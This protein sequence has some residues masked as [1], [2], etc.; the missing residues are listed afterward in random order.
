MFFLG[1]EF[2]KR[3][4]FCGDQLTVERARGS[5][6]ARIN[7]DTE[8]EAL[9]GLEPAVADWH[10][11]ANFLQ[12]SLIFVNVHVYHGHICCVPEAYAIPR[13]LCITSDLLHTL[14][15]YRQYSLG[16]IKVDQVSKEELCFNFEI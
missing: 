7:S 1:Y 12:V 6:Q 15:F 2:T 10:S 11:E 16:F 3:L 14:A 4:L 5:Q 8:K 9:L 13:A